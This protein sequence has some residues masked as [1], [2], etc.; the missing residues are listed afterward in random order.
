MENDCDATNADAD[1]IRRSNNPQNP[2]ISF[3]VYLPKQTSVQLLHAVSY[4]GI[5]KPK[6]HEPAGQI[7]MYVGDSQAKTRAP[8][9]I[10]LPMESCDGDCASKR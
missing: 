9:L 2:L 8:K 4:C 5:S 6:K 1:A 7:A 10:M 3:C